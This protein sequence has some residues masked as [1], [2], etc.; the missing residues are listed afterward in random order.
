[1][2]VRPAVVSRTA[3]KVTIHHWVWTV[4]YTLFM[5]R[6]VYYGLCPV[7]SFAVVLTMSLADED[8]DGLPLGAGQDGNMLILIFY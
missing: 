2:N 3:E 7:L 4:L 5:L 6:H 1:M 8:K